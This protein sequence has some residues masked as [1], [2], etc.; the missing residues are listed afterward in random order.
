[1]SRFTSRAVSRTDT[2]SDIHHN[3]Q[4][5]ALTGAGL[6]AFAVFHAPIIG[7]AIV[8]SLMHGTLSGKS[9]A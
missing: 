1:M 2:I 8:G 9:A 4:H 3:V 5:L 6:T 7:A